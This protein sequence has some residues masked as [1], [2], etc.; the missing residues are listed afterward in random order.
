MKI[1]FAINCELRRCPLSKGTSEAE[2]LYFMLPMANQDERSG[3]VYLF[4]IW[5]ICEQISE[6]HKSSISSCS[7]S[8]G[9]GRGEV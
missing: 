5:K 9:E 1:L 4:L 8:A 6:R 7:L 3:G 2:G